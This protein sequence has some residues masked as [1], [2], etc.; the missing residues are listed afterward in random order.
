MFRFS[1]ATFLVDE[2]VMLA[3]R[4]ISSYSR[5]ESN[6]RVVPWQTAALL[7]LTA[8]FHNKLPF[9]NASVVKSM[10]LFCQ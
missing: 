10:L 9:I 7:Q 6:R 1:L 5:R 3:T 8:M 2:G 4:I